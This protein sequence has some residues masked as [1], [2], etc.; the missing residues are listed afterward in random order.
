MSAVFAASTLWRR[1]SVLI[2]D[3]EFEQMAEAIR[4]IPIERLNSDDMYP[5]WEN[6]ESGWIEKILATGS[7]LEPGEPDG[8]QIADEARDELIAAA[9]LIRTEMNSDN[10]PEGGIIHIGPY[11]VLIFAEASYG[12]VSDAANAIE[13][14]AGAIDLKQW[15]FYTE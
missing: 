11:E 4:A 1:G 7:D 15:G 6:A 13:A 14:L 3:E 10:S 2:T 9:E 5:L 8:G 12:D